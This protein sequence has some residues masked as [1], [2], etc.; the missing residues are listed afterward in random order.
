M[1]G[2]C[3]VAEGA[4]K[5][6]ANLWVWSKPPMSTLAPH[7]RLQEQVAPPPPNNNNTH[8]HTHTRT[9]TRAPHKDMSP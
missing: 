8:T 6:G 4:E 5:W 7:L 3:P 1:H 2:G 9:H